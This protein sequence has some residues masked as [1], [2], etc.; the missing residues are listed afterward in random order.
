MERTFDYDLIHTT[1]VILTTGS[2]A[3]YLPCNANITEEDAHVI[4]LA[5]ADHGGNFLHNDEE[6]SVYTGWLI[7]DRND[8]RACYD[9]TDETGRWAGDADETRARQLFDAFVR[10]SHRAA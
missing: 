6:A 3:R 4:A 7:I 2:G 10:D 8:D 9:L 5:L 1:A